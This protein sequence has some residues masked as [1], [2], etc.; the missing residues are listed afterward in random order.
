MP[1][2]MKT[3]ELCIFRHFGIRYIGEKYIRKNKKR[4]IDSYPNPISKLLYTKNLIQERM[5]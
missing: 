3:K 5:K 4:Y 2:N 1:I